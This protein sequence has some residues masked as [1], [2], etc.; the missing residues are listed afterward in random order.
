M[1]RAW[2][3]FILASLTFFLSQFYRA[4]NAV[5]SPQLVADLSLDTE[6]LGLLSASFFY[7]FAVTQIPITLLLDRVGA[8]KMMSALMLVGIAGAMIFSM[9]KDLNVGIVG[10]ILMGAGMACNLMGTLKLLTLWFGPLRFATLSGI[11][12][13]IGS[14]GNMAATSPYV[15]VVERMG[16]RLSFK[17]IAILNLLILMV[18]FRV[19]QEKPVSAPRKGEGIGSDLRLLLRRKNFWII[20]AA[21]MVNYGVF[22]AFQTLWA[23]PFLIEAIGLSPLYAGNLI[24]L[25]NLASIVGSPIWGYLSDR[26]KTRKWIIFGGQLMLALVTFM[27]VGVRPRTGVGVLAM[28]FFGFGFFRVTGSLM[29][30]QIKESMPVRMAG[31]AMTGIN[32]FTML[33][34]AIFLQGLGTLMQTYYPAASRGQEA[35]AVAF[36]LCAAL[37]A[38]ISIVYLFTDDTISVK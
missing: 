8:R 20:S 17:A 22:A 26:L 28:L 24:F 37:I 38:G 32:F 27:M 29:Y 11:V 34:P 30:A 18:F 31:T 35:F 3:V 10:R 4:A 14:M 36:F 9:A 7:A 19:V 23:G 33:G 2:A 21:T 15:L 16:W 1:S 6:G 13:A 12:F 5:I 25:I